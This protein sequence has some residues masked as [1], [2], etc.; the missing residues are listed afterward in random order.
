MQDFPIAFVT[1]TEPPGLEIRINFGVLAGR[2]AT[3]AELDDLG[4]SLLPH[5]GEISVVSEERHELSE[6]VE[7]SLHQVRIEIDDVRVPASPAE[8]DALARELVGAAERWAQTCAD[9][10]TTGVSE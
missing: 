8:R 1:R 9:E 5:V 3:P 4:H 6:V 10:R 2:A 7:A